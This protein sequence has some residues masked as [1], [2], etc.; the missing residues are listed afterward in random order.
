MSCINAWLIVLLQVVEGLE[1]KLQRQHEGALDM[2]RQQL[3]VQRGAQ[4]GEGGF[5][6]KGMIE[7]NGKK[8][9]TKGS[10][11]RGGEE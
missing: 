9:R 11:I 3:K 6:R 7:L 4:V 1:E 5:G 8:V 10:M 2:L